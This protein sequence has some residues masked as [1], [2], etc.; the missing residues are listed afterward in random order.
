[1]ISVLNTNSRVNAQLKKSDHFGTLTWNG[2]SPEVVQ[3]ID[4]P[5]QAPLVAGETIITG[6]RSTI[7]PKGIPIGT[8][9]SFEMDET[10][11]Y[12]TVNINL[13]NDMT[14]IGHVHVIE[15]LDREEIKT[16]ELEND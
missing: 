11:N 15:N 8:I 13:F 12:Y 4:I 3:L 6:G 14:N 2:D 1:M 7:F 16:L 9:V 5:K 10:E